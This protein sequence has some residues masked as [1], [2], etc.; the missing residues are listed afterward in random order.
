[1]NKIDR[2][3]PA[4]ITVVE[5]SE[6][7]EHRVAYNSIDPSGSVTQNL[8]GNVYKQMVEAEKAAE[9]LAKAANVRFF[10][11]AEESGETSDGI[12]ASVLFRMGVACW[13]E[14]RA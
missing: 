1:M 12:A 7:S 8:V 10:S 14:D 11:P 4:Y 5:N 13:Q 3:L 6:T 9:T 2:S